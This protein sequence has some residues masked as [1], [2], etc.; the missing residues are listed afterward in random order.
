MVI[1]THFVLEMKN[2]VRNVVTQNSRGGRA[3]VS[4]DTYWPMLK[5]LGN[6]GL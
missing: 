3:F 6:L 2:I 5:I 1:I 4:L